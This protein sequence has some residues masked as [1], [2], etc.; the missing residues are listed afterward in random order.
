MHREFYRFVANKD[1]NPRY[2][3]HYNTDAPLNIRALFYIPQYKPS[4]CGINQ[5][6]ESIL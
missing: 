1:D 4:K 3:L 5:M 2:M 6:G